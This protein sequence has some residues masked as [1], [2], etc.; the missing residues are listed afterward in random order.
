MPQHGRADA[1]DA[2]ADG[3]LGVDEVDRG[4]ER[5]TAQHHSGMLLSRL[6]RVPARYG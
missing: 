2:G 1:D 4:W 6:E 3:R 5:A